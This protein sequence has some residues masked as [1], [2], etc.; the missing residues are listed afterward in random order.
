MNTPLR[1]LLIDDDELDRQ[2]VLRALR[3]GS[4]D[5]EV[6]QATTAAAGLKLALEEVFD[7]ILLDYRLPDQ[8]GLDVLRKLRGAEHK[9]CLLYTSRCV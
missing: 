1:L 7:I 3:Q 4:V 8:D 9:G 5:S 2:A 6:S